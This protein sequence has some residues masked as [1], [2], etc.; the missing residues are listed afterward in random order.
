LL[1]L[2]YFE[3]K[4]DVNIRKKDVNISTERKKDIFITSANDELVINRQ[5]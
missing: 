2:I 5:I 4:C 1:Y 3:Y